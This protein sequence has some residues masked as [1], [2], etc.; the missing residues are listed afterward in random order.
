MQIETEKDEQSSHMATLRVTVSELQVTR[1][2]IIMCAYY[3]F[4]GYTL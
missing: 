2:Y 4:S 3:Q 1:N